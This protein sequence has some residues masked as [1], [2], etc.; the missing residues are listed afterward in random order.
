M[1][2]ISPTKIAFQPSMSC[3]SVSSTPRDERKA[4][5]KISSLTSPFSCRWY[6][7][8]RKKRCPSCIGS[9][10]ERRAQ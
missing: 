6:N 4:A 5:K 8:S 7:S 10:P 2:G 1:P 3:A 9:Q